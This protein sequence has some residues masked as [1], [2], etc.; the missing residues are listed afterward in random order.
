MTEIFLLLFVSLTL[1]IFF[2]I[3]YQIKVK[4][5]TNSILAQGNS[6]SL[7]PNITHAHERFTL[8]LERI[9]P[10]NLLK[11]IQAENTLEFQR[12]IINTI[13]AEYEH[14]LALQVYIKPETWTQIQSAKE[15]LTAEVI[16]LN[17]KSS[18]K[19]AQIHLLSL[20]ESSKQIELALKS[21]KN[22]I[23]VRI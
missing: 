11:R 2:Y 20:T 18:I 1:L 23:L 17:L 13:S 7:L 8:F 10:E 12:D 14:N 16:A 3:F 19:D 5:K 4:N 21:L 15:I 6:P 9:K 22:D